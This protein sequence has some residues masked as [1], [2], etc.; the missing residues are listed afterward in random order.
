MIGIERKTELLG[1]GVYSTVSAEWDPLL[2]HAVAV[3][4][5]HGPLAQNEAFARAFLAKAE[6]LF[7]LEHE[8]VL[9][10]FRVDGSRQ[11][12]A[13]VREIA[14]DTL[15]AASLAGPLPPARVEEI[16]RQALL[17]LRA[18]HARGVIHGAVKSRNLFF[19]CGDQVKIGDFGVTD[20]PGAP[21]AAMSSYL[22]PELLRG[23][24]ASPASDLYALG[25]TA[26]ELLLGRAR[27]EQ[28]SRLDLPPLDELL[29]GL[30]RTLSLGVEQMTRKSVAYR[31][32]G[33]DQALA[34]L[35]VLEADGTRSSSSPATGI[36]ALDARLR[37]EAPKP[38]VD[39]QK[40]KWIV[41]GAAA[42]LLV[43]FGVVA[44]VFLRGQSFTGV[45]AVAPKAAPAKPGP[46]PQPPPAAAPQAAAMTTQ[47]PTQGTAGPV[48]VPTAPPQTLP[49]PAPPPQTAS[50]EPASAPQ[51]KPQP[52]SDLQPTNQ[53]VEEEQAPQEAPAKKM[54]IAREIIQGLQPSRYGLGAL[55]SGQRAYVDLDAVYSDVPWQRDRIPCIQTA[56]AD[57]E[58]QG[59]LSF[60]L[61]RD[62]RVYVGHDRSIKRKPS[63]LQDFHPTGETWSVLVRNAGSSGDAG[64]AVIYFDV[65]TR[66]YPTGTVSLGPNMGTGL[67]SRFK[68]LSKQLLGRG[69]PSM[70]LVCVDP[71]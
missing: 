60:E 31:A 30:P 38:V 54:P 34:A 46:S 71:R 55:H 3:K 7:D 69:E 2:G 35:G 50:K 6:R 52:G 53:T 40:V 43:A 47:E 45:S 4:E 25:I 11:A 19:Q 70:Y 29:P 23:E 33:A 64:S 20:V 63:W 56:V 24:P 8:H 17:G 57:R 12:P 61:S 14:D 62:A 42:I 51:T 28:L 39:V 9:T 49:K 26:Y 66:S 36:S 67:F 44:T 18:M 13:F 68:S 58:G 15:E 65:F 59:T 37:P 41:A 21:P 5:L 32:A 1:S 48:S 16:L 22:A 10:V 27:F